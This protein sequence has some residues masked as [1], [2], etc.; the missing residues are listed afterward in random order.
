MP[1]QHSWFVNQRV[2]HL[3]LT[4]DVSL[5]ELTDAARVSN[6]LVKSGIPLV[7]ELIDMR[8]MRQFP[9]TLSKLAWLVPYLSEPDLGWVLVVTHNVLVS[10]LSNTLGQIS[11]ARLRV[12]DTPQDAL[13]FIADMDRTLPPLPPYA[14]LSAT[15]VA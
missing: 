9:N 15:E 6:A 14:D 8:D 12:F 2:L 13:D 3:Q 11:R 4:G 5:E 1:F 7:H 10:F